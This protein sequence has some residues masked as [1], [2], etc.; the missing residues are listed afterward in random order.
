MENRKGITPV[1][2]IV[3]LLMMTVAAAGLAYMWVIG[4]QQEAQTG[5]ETQVQQIQQQAAAQLT[6]DTVYNETGNIDFVLRNSGTYAFS[7]TDV[8]NF[9]YYIDG[10]TITPNV[11]C[12][13]TLATGKTCTVET[14]STFPIEVGTD[15]SKIIKVVPPVGSA[16]S[17]T[18]SIS[19]VDQTY[20]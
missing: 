16:I 12:P 9:A 11:A 19:K 8:S 14:S 15:G 17:Y 10:K 6:I 20:C 13:G 1:I 7:T 5:I 3:L 18:C 4:V 2:A